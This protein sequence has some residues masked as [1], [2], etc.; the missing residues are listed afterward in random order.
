ME[1]KTERSFKSI[2]SLIVFIVVGLFQTEMVNASGSGKNYYF[3][4]SFFIFYFI[5]GTFLRILRDPP[6]ALA[7][8]PPRQNTELKIV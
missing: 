3:S 1:R 4:P 2:Y 7:P 5:F 6:H 8:T